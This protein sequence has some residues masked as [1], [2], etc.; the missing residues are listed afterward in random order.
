MVSSVL[1][2][3]DA[4]NV[5]WL[6]YCLLFCVINGWTTSE[7]LWYIVSAS[8]N[9]NLN[10]QRRFTLNPNHTKIH[11]KMC[12]IDVIAENIL[13]MKSDY[14]TQMQKEYRIRND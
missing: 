11:K 10:D 7:R 13:K 9:G 12:K 4:L 5:F 3:R 8:E 1:S 2:L 14:W 6:L